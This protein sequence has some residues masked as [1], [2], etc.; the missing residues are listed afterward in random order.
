[1]VMEDASVIALTIGSMDQADRSEAI[2]RLEK[3]AG[4]IDQL[5]GAARALA[6]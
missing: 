1:M 5:I 4:R 2:A 3:D 6:S